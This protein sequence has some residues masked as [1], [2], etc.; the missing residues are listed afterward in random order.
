MTPFI[1]NGRLS[2]F[3]GKGYNMSLYIE[4]DEVEAC[5]CGYR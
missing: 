5:F 3:S 4:L 1:F 2:G